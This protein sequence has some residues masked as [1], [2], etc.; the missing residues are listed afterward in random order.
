MGHYE[1]KPNIQSR[2]MQGGTVYLLFNPYYIL[3]LDSKSSPE[4]F[5]YISGRG[6]LFSCLSSDSTLIN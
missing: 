4:H 6:V 2:T 3:N 1:V 5:R